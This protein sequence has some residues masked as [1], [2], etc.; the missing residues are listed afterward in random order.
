MILHSD[1]QLI[2]QVIELKVAPPRIAI[3]QASAVIRT[4]FRQKPQKT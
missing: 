1:T 2:I 4:K 3:P